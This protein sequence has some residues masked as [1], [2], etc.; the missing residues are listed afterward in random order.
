MS[1]WLYCTIPLKLC[2]FELQDWHSIQCFAKVSLSLSVFPY[3]CIHLPS[4]HTE[5]N[6]HTCSLQKFGQSEAYCQV[7]LKQKA[8]IQ[9]KPVSFSSKHFFVSFIYQVVIL[10]FTYLGFHKHQPHVSH[11]TALREIMCV[12]SSHF[13]ALL[14]QEAMD[15]R[16]LIGDGSLYNYRNIPMI[17]LFLFCIVMLGHKGTNNQ[18]LTG[19]SPLSASLPFSLL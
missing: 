17:A 5:T 3:P 8:L 18:L 11:S 6:V 4:Q 9:S 10:D 7:H 13:E 15:W 19:L 16:T 2:N 1:Y 12:T 14:I